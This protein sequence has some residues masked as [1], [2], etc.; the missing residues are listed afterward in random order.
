V[1]ARERI[2]YH[3]VRQVRFLMLPR[4]GI[5][6]GDG[7]SDIETPWPTP[8]VNESVHPTAGLSRKRPP[9]RGVDEHQQC[10][11]RNPHASLLDLAR[12]ASVLLDRLAR[13]SAKLLMG[14]VPFVLEMQY[15]SSIRA[16]DVSPDGRLSH[17]LY[18]SRPQCCR[19]A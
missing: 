18:H 1:D 19:H 4:G 12:P 5:K 15:R 13:N 8:T 3:Y 17:I 14:N 10:H 16:S 6:E 9:V 7:G 11:H 2:Q